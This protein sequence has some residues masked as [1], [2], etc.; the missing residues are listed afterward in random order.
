MRLLDCSPLSSV[1]LQLPTP[2]AICNPS[3]AQIGPDLR[4]L[5]RALEPRPWQTHGDQALS[6]ENWMVD[7]DQDLQPRAHF[8]IDDS[9][10]R[11][12]L[13]LARHGLEDGRLF[14]WQ[15]Q[16]WML[17]SG[18]ARTGGDCRNTMLVA[19]LEGERLVDALPLPSPHGRSRE[20]NWMPCVSEG[21][22]HLVYSVEPLEV[23]RVAG[24]RLAPVHRVAPATPS[25]AAWLS[26]SSQLL[27]WQDG[28][29]AVVH[30]RRPRA[31][32]QRLW[33]KHVQRDPDY[34]VRKVRFTHQLLAF[35]HDFTLRARS[36]EFTF[37]TDGVEFCAGIVLQGERIVFSYGVLDRAAV[38]R[39][40]DIRLVDQLLGMTDARA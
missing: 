34:A 25:P 21:A 37:E 5:L 33:M 6:S 31:G 10:V 39:A 24:E 32:L 8:R 22:L 27:P 15:G 3:I 20:K 16:P 36:P 29:L 4:V 26:G 14:E 12:Q 30:R 13:A 1:R 11:A 7:V 2:L 17:F 28:F 23:L 40:F 38:L 35:N 19:R 18:L 9:A